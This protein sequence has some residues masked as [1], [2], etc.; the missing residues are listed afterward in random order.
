MYPA[1]QKIVTTLQALEMTK[2][3]CATEEHCQFD[4]RRKLATWKI[5]E[6]KSEWIIGEL[7]SEGYINE[8]RFARAFARG[9]FNIKSWGKQKITAELKKR[10]ISDYC[11]KQAL[12]EINE[13][14]YK[15]RLNDVAIK[16]LNQH[17]N[18]T[19]IVKKQKLFRYLV[20]KGYQMNEIWDF[21]NR[22]L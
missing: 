1:K 16:W 12:S 3:Y 18:E 8:E 15:E 13:D 2:N 11:I 21:I 9:K 4:V 17:K 19:V 14:N 20:S 10:N 7:I 22:K 6:E 5:D